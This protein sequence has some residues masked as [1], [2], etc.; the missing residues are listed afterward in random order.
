M[1][2]HC[3]RTAPLVP[4]TTAGRLVSLLHHQFAVAARQHA[5]V[6][7]TS[8]AAEPAVS[9]AVELLPLRSGTRTAHTLDGLWDFYLDP[10][11]TGLADGWHHGLPADRKR[12]VAVP[13]SWTEQLAGEQHSEGPG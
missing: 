7:T 10:D 12:T 6:T 2:L 9:A 1:H 3:A 13:G 8:A 4:D 11:D 5:G